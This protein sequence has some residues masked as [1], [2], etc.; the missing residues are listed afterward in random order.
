[1]A[2]DNKEY[3]YILKVSFEIPAKS[4]R[5]ESLMFFINYML[6]NKENEKEF[7]K[8]H[9]IYSVKYEFIEND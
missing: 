6:S 5:I 4:N 1:M 8:N 2:K 7:V 9:E 3:P